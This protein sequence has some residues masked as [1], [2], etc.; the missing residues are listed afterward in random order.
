MECERLGAAAMLVV[1]A[2][3]AGLGSLRI[4][5]QQ[6]NASHRQELMQSCKAS[7]QNF[8]DADCVTW[9][10]RA[11]YVRKASCPD[12]DAR[13]ACSSFRELVEANDS[14]IMNALAEK[15]SVY[16]CFRPGEDVFIDVYF[17]GPNDGTW[18]RD[19]RNS[20]VASTQGG[21]AALYYKGGIGSGDMSFPED[22]GKWKY[23]NLTSSMNVATL[24]VPFSNAIF[25]SDDISIKGSRF[26]AAKTYKNDV[27]TN[28]E[29][30]LVVELSTGRFLETYKSQLLGRVVESYSGRC[31]ILPPAVHSE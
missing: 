25:Q 6:T 3:A 28:I 7:N 18:E 17:S 10:T 9:L 14:G 15:A 5:G 4:S 22:P 20:S 23:L 29:H 13:T 8:T 2:L 24:H 16:A 26:Q 30:A 27:G 31:L 21:A 19:S 12:R 1:V 11:D